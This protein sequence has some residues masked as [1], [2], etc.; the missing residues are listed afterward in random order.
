MLADVE[1]IAPNIGG[2]MDD[3]SVQKPAQKDSKNAPITIEDISPL[4]NNTPTQDDFTVNEYVMRNTMF[5][6]KH[7][8]KKINNAIDAI[9]DKWPKGT[10]LEIWVGFDLANCCP[11]ELLDKLD[12]ADFK[13]QVKTELNRR[14]SHQP[15]SQ[16]ST[17]GEMN[18]D[19]DDDDDDDHDDKTDAEFACNVVTQTKKTA[20]RRRK[21]SKKNPVSDGPIPPTPNGVS[22]E[23]WR[24]W[25]D[26]HRKSYL[27][28]M[29]DPNT[30]LY[31][32]CPVGVQRKNGPWTEDEKRLFI[33]RL[34]QIRGDKDTIDG[35]WG[36][37]SLGV[38]GRVGYQCSNFY[39]LL[40]SLGE[41]KDSRYV[42]GSD[43]KLHHTSHFHPEREGNPTAKKSTRAPTKTYSINSVNSLKFVLHKNSRSR[44]AENDENDDEDGNKPVK[45][46]GRYDRW[47]LQN[48]IPDA[49]DQITGEVM[50]VPTIS[51][52]GYVLDYNTWLNVLKSAPQN[53][54]T[55]N[56]LNKRDLVVLTIENYEEYRKD[57][58][59]L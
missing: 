1:S 56:H 18:N 12:E 41:I 26:I 30:F 3:T 29:K 7:K 51:P 19:A 20:T 23:E 57:I 15:I 24:S 27:A 50:K 6:A 13:Q 2:E 16:P 39:R 45:M 8:L 53:P 34:N 59:N 9:R 32:N 10:P 43:G 21:F 17:E 31:R 35:K 49:I 47:A 48:P 25:S 55:R 38:P 58:K 28:G 11:E 52:D 22:D 37:F 54:F 40:I 14:L 4:L 46:L 33:K 5:M 44:L 42:I 36:I